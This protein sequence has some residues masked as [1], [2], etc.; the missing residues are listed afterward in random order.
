LSAFNILAVVQSGRL[1]YEALLLASS[2]R[3]SAPGF[4]GKLFLAQPGGPLWAQNVAVSPA[5]GAAL[6]GLGATILPFENRAF[7]AS[8][9]HGNKIEALLA[10]PDEP[11]LFLDTDTLITGD[12]SA[13]PF[14]F[15]RPSASMRREGTWPQVP[16]YST[17][18]AIWGGLYRQFGLDITPTLDMREP[19]D[20]WRRFLYFNAGWFFHASPRTFGERFL[21]YAKAIRDTPPESLAAQELFPWLDQIALPLT[22]HALGGGR[23]GAELAGMDGDVTCHYRSLPLLYARESDLV[24][25]V[26]EQVA[27]QK[28]LRRLLRDHEPVRELVYKNRGCKIRKMFDRADLPRREQAIRA[29]IKEV[30][31]WLR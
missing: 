15:K 18:E 12:I 13:V 20:H 28:E 17:Y 24:V 1:G 10:L 25:K 31:L 22:V 29:R 16:A 5:I 21:T 26:L 4:R 30:G 8:Y 2:L 9:P 11:F 23:P 7:G 6:E 27:G 3:A 14:D 19:A